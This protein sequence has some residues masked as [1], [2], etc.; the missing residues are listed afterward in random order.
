MVGTVER[1]GKQDD[2][3]FYALDIR[4]ATDFA[5]L[6]NVRVIRNYTQAEHRLI[7]QEASEND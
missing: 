7:Q 2:N 3:N 6:S 5:T 1:L 4:L